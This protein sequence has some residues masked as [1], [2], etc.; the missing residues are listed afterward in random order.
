MIP[1]SKMYYLFEDLDRFS[2]NLCG[3]VALAPILVTINTGRIRLIS[4]WVSLALGQCCL[5]EM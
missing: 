3:Q 1:E 2:R 4:P 5:T